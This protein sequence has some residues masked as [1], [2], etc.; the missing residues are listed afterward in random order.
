L[1]FNYLMASMASKIVKCTGCPIRR[2]LNSLQN[3]GNQY[4]EAVNEEFQVG[5]DTYANRAD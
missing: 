1:R 3:Y 2:I 5:F 4:I